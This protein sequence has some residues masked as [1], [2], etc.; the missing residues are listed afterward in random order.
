MIKKI[1]IGQLMLIFIVG[2]SFAGDRYN[3]VGTKV[4]ND[5][6]Q[7]TK[8]QTNQTYVNYPLVFEGAKFGPDYWI[9]A[10]VPIDGLSGYYD[11][12]TNGENK[13]Q[14][15]RFSSTVL[16]AIKMTSLDSVD[17][18][19]SRRTRYAFSDDDGATWT[20]ITDVPFIRSGFASLECLSDG[21]ALVGNHYQPGAF[22]TTLLNYDVAPGAGSFTEVFAPYNFIWPG[23]AKYSNGNILV[24]GE[25][26]IGA[27]ATDTGAVCVFNASNFTFSPLT[28]LYSSATS[29]LNMRW[30]YAAGPNGSGIYVLD[31]ISDA[32]GNFGLNRIFIFKT[33]D[34]GT[35]WDNGAV[36]FDP[37]IIGSDTLGPFFGLDAIY[38]NAGNYYVAFNTLDPGNSFA[39]AKMWVSKNSGTP[40]I[41]AQHSG[42]NGIPE[43]ANTVL[44]ADAGISTIDHPALSISA[45]GNWIFCAFSV[46]YEADTLNGY[47]KCHIYYSG[48]Q[49]STLDFFEPIQVTE[50]GPASMDERYVSLH[51]VAPDLGGAEGITLYMLYQKDPQPGSCAFNDLAPV[52]RSQHVFRKIHNAETPIG[53]TNIGSE[54]PRIYSLQQNFPNPFNPVT[55]I[56]FDLPQSGNVTLKVFNAAGQLVAVLANNE[57]TSAGVKEVNFNGTGFASGVYFYSISVGDF[58][59]TKKMVLVK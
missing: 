43:A 55:K 8:V 7:E 27:A 9:T 50:S 29:H 13:H 44:S 10:E 32:G 36:M 11:Y 52:S 59:Q 46:Q 22:L 35:T 25:T 30:T 31:A 53:I 3:K 48:S 33:T 14:I 39:S 26:Y 17:Q 1:L 16:H 19:G 24:A 4:K 51:R 28:R 37:M 12:E 40:V 18:N 56:R 41:V 34:N 49:T 47:N 6:S 15:N 23:L 38:D 45:D 20:Y 5:F 54:I 2:V 21:V 57:F 58:T 42:E